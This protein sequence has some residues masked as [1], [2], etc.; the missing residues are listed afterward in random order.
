MLAAALWATA[1]GAADAPSPSWKPGRTAV[2]WDWERHWNYWMEWRCTRQAVVPVVGSMKCMRWAKVGAVWKPCGPAIRPPQPGRTNTC[3]IGQRGG[4]SPH[5]N[6]LTV[7]F[8]YLGRHED[9]TGPTYAVCLGNR[10]KPANTRAGNCGTWVR[11]AHRHCPGRPKEHPPCT[12]PSSTAPPVTAPP[13]T[14]PPNTAPPVTAPPGTVQPR[15]T[16]TRPPVTT[17]PSVTFRPRTRPTRPPTTRPPVT[18]RPTTTTTQPVPACRKPGAEAAFRDAVD[19]LPAPSLG[20]QPSKHGYVGAPIRIRYNRNPN[21]SS[22]T[23]IGG[24]RIYLRVWVSSMTWSFTGLG[25]K[26]GRWIGSAAVSRTASDRFSAPRLVNP[27]TALVEGRKAV[28]LRSSAAA[29]Y[30]DGY[31]ITLSITWRAECR[32]HGKSVWKA[33]SSQTWRYGHTYRVYDVRSRSS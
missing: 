25:T 22:S 21:A 6:G 27:A 15:S 11:T 7:K 13:N 20:I 12:A 14:A 16:T 31:P 2:T 8:T 18:T 26:D 19:R 10:S 24:D 30:P 17:R 9:R 5:G 33:L 4:H 23:Q 3:N 32:E 29:G 28:F 1:P